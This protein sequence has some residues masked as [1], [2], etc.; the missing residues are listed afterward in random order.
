MKTV[1]PPTVGDV[2]L[3]EGHAARRDHVLELLERAQVLARWRPA[4]RRRARRARGPATSSGIVGSSSQ[5][6]SKRLRA[7]AA[8]IRLVDA[9]LHVG[10]DH[11][12]EAGRPGARAS[13]RTRST[14]SD[15][16]ARPTFILIAR[17][18]FSRDCRRSGAGARSSGQSRSI[19]RRSRAPGGRSRR[20]APERLVR[21][22]GPAGPT[23][24]CRRRRG[25]RW[26][27]AAAAVVQRP[28]HL[29]PEPLDLVG[30][31]CP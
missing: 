29:L 22:A 24:R 17:K 26:R 28:P 5:V 10:V 27:A 1:M 21:R 8:R 7:R 3:G 19:R 12:R 18:P 15:S 2:G 30:R 13:R 11:Q 31:R 20:E 6:R 4:G 9:P 25:P 16:R 23:A 14:S